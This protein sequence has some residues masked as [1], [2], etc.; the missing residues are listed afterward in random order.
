MTYETKKNVPFFYKAQKKN[1]K[2]VPFFY[3]EQKRTQRSFRSLKN[4]EKNPKIIPFFYKEQKRMQRSEPG[5]GIRSFQKNVPLFP[6][7]CVLL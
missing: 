5:L 2:I 1:T 3:K 7:F 6:F 4:P